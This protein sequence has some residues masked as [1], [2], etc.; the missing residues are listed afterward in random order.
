[1]ELF[2]SNCMPFIE[3][4]L[5]QFNFELP[6]YQI[7]TRHAKFINSEAARIGLYVCDIGL[8]YFA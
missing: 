8:H 2:R 3:F 7:A 5:E 6:S 1:M 4:Y